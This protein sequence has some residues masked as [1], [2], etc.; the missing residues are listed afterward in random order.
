MVRGGQRKTQSLK[1][2]EIK[3]QLSFPSYLRQIIDFGP[4]NDLL[5]ALQS[6]KCHLVSRRRTE[7]KHRKR[8]AEVLGEKEH[9]NCIL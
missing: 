7:T 2:Q 5:I 1:Q 3:P 4:H 9:I 8:R 6:V